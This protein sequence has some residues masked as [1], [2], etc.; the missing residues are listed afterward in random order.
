MDEPGLEGSLQPWLP[1]SCKGPGSQSFSDNLTLVTAPSHFLQPYSPLSH[2]LQKGLLDVLASPTYTHTPLGPASMSFP[3]TSLDPLL[4][5]FLH[6]NISFTTS[7]LP[8]IQ[9]SVDQAQ[10]SGP[11]P[12]PGSISKP[13]GGLREFGNVP[14][15]Q[16]RWRD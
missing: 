2:L 16:Y 10:G 15:P 8:L 12:Y 11:H 7:G 5:S 14:H 13:C 4:P 3:V 9:H 6:V 1:P